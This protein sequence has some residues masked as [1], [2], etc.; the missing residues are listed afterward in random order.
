MELYKISPDGAQWG[1]IYNN[2]LVAYHS[3]HLPG[4]HCPECDQKWATIGMAYP[5]VDLSGTSL[6]KQLEKARNVELEVFEAL[7]DAVKPYARTGLPLP[8]GTEFGPVKGK[9]KGKF[10]DFIW[11]HLWDPMIRVEAYQQLASTG[12]HL[13][14]TVAPILQEK[15]QG[16]LFQL[17]IEPYGCLS[18]QSYIDPDTPICQRC[19]RDG[20][21]LKELVLVRASIPN[22][23]DMFRIGNFPTKVLVSQDF[24]EAVEQFGFT[25]I[26]FEKVEIE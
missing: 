13:P 26:L 7:Q 8:P 3:W 5:L 2:Y 17:Q 14:G 24:K 6:G 12:L 15:V 19:K 20:R 21:K 16:Q 25:N 18:P 11:R 22:H 23:L 10:G 1:K 9:V 4:V